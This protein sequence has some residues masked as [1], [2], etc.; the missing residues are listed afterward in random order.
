ME[1]AMLERS[2]VA[3]VGAGVMAEAVI[4]GLLGK[5]LIDP[6][7]IRAADVRPER[8]RELAQRCKARMWP[9]CP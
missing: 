5:K 7:R 9:C 6:A 8:G 4:K 3:F 2:T 1:A